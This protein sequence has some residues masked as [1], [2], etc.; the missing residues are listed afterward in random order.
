MQPVQIIPEPQGHSLSSQAPGG[1]HPAWMNDCIAHPTPGPPRLHGPPRAPCAWEQCGVQTG[2]A[3]GV[4]QW[5]AFLHWSSVWETSGMWRW[6][7]QWQSPTHIAHHLHCD[8]YHVHILAY[9]HLHAAIIHLIFGSGVFILRLPTYKHVAG[10][11]SFYR[12]SCFNLS[13]FW[14]ERWALLLF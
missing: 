13:T 12:S 3:G 6:S 1:H 9:V 5:G 2:E 7:S 11:V 14:T 8:L 10:L 4:C